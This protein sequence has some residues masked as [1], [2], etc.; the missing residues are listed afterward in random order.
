MNDVDTAIDFDTI[1]NILLRSARGAQHMRTRAGL[2]I[3]GE[4]SPLII[5]ASPQDPFH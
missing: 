4:K 5:G 3:S 1:T 2:S